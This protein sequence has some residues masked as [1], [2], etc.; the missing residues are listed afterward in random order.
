LCVT[1]D[2]VQLTLET[3]DVSDAGDDSQS[4]KNFKQKSLFLKNKRR[5]L[6]F[7]PLPLFIPFIPRIEGG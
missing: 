1:F 3:A 7:L 6:S 4:P 2:R 5:R